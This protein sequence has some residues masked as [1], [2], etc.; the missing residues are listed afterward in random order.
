MKSLESSDM[1]TVGWISALPI[2]RA[3]AIAML[4]ERHDKPCGFV[5]HQADSNSY[6]W[7]RMGEH[8]VVIASLPAGLYGT[9]SAATTASSLLSSLPNIRISL[10]VGIGGGIARPEQGR[11]IRLGDIVVS[12]PRGTTGGLLQYDLG[13]ALSN[14]RWERKGF[15]SLPPRVLLHALASLQAEHELGE[16]RVP[17]FLTAAEKLKKGANWYSYQGFEHDRLFRSSYGH[18]GGHDC[19]DCEEMQTVDRA[20]RETTD[21]EV[22]YGIIA[23]GNTLVKDA[24]S[25]DRMFEEIG[26][27][28]ICLEMEAAGLMNHFPCLVI[29]GVSDYADSHKNDRWQRY[30]SATAAAYGKELLSYVPTAELQET[31]TALEVLSSDIQ[32]IHAIVSVTKT[33]VESLES[34][35]HLD[36]IRTWLSAPDTSTNLNEAQKKRQAGTGLWFL[37][38]ASFQEW[39][40]GTRQTL[41]LYG[42]PGC[43]KTVLSAS[44]IDYLNQQLHSTG[45]ILE[46]FFDFTDTKK[47]TLDQLVR[48]LIGQLYLRSKDTRKELDRVIKAYKNSDRQPTCESLSTAFQQLLSHV[49]KGMVSIRPGS[50][51]TDIRLYVHEQLRNGRDFARWCSKPTVLDEIETGI[52]QRADGMFRLAVCQLDNLQK[53]LDLPRLRKSLQL[54]PRTLEEMYARI[55]NGIDE[56]YRDC[57]IR[58]LQ[59][60][61][62]SEPPLTIEEAVDIVAIDPSGHPVFDPTFRMPDPREIGKFCPSLVT[63]VVREQRYRKSWTE[64]QL[65]HLSVQQYLKSDRIV[66]SFDPKSSD[67]GMLFQNSLNLTVASGDITTVCLQ[68]L[69]QLDTRKSTGELAKEYPFFVYSARYWMGHAKICETEKHVLD[70]IL[71]FFLEQV[72]AYEAWEQAF[73][74]D[75]S[76]PPVFEPGYEKMPPLYYA[77]LAGLQHTVQLLLNRE[78]DL[79]VHG[80]DALQAASMGGCTEAVQLPFRNGADVNIQGGH[81]G[82]A[83]QAASAGG[84]TEVMQLLLRNGAD[85]N[86]QGGEFDNAL[87]AASLRG[88]TEDV[89]L[90]LRNGADVNIQGGHFGNALQGASSRGHLEIVQLLFRNGADMNK[91]GGLFDTALQAA[92]AGGYTEVMQLL[93]RNG[94]DVNIQGGYFGNALQAASAGGYT[95]V[96]QLLLRN[97]ADV[98]I[99]GGEFGNALQAASLRGHT[100]DVQLLLR[101][102]ADVNI[103][104]GE[105]GNALQ[106]ASLRGHTEVM[107]LL[108]RNGAKNTRSLV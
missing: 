32:Q 85:V 101:N 105:F 33:A 2:E 72:E 50:V 64:L 69:S 52:M 71:K 27:E 65:A 89:Q 92:S 106:A 48:S 70:R 56:D 99:Q 54:L 5:Q 24:I 76:V 15:L 8:N 34:N 21:P 35:R 46:F 97:G 14:Q 31:R 3:A 60:L 66:S 95:E 84:Y 96:M 36:Q 59:F 41:W 63:L 91:R 81:F 26:E 75:P 55:L 4:D 11:D 90:L 77:A 87:Q 13:K 38:S 82:N 102:G 44:I 19:H 22:H 88:H 83:L 29:R 10:L 40:V 74:L 104:G 67:V 18:K 79:K 58:I 12:E 16:S 28:C 20:E 42:I 108:L 53:H 47:Q 39:Y 37:E 78:G 1:Y 23:S 57:A 107:Q 86:I 51:N 94:A 17:E 45:V 80:E 49:Q 62:Y 73:C 61:T 43:G 9:T 68:Y 7:G 103:Q 25:R 98:N 93:L 6:S 30:A 100:E